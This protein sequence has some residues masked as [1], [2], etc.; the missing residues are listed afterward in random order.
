MEDSREAREREWR[1][2]GKQ[3]RVWGI[4]GKKGKGERVEDSGEGED[5]VML[6]TL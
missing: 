1:I 4:V 5:A 2:A 3:G 6:S